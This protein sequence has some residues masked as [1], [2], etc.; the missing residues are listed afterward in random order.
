MKFNKIIRNIAW[1]AVAAFCVVPAN[2][3]TNLPEGAFPTLITPHQQTINYRERTLCLDITANVAY[4]F[5]SDAEWAT[6]RK[7]ADGSVYLHL[8][9]NYGGESRVANITFTCATNPELNQTLV[10]TQGRNEAVEDLP[11]DTQIKP[12]SATANNSQSGNGIEKTYDGDLDT[13]YHT[14][15]TGNRFTV[16]ESNPAI[17]TYNFTDVDRIDYVQYVPRRDNVTNGNFMNVEV[18]VKREGDADYTTYATYEWGGGSSP[19]TVNFEGG[20]LNPVSI[21]FVV[22]KGVGDHASC[23][24]MQFCLLNESKDDVFNLFKDDLCSELKDGVTLADIE[25]CTSTFAQSLAMQLYNGTYEKNY[26]IAEYPC[27]LDPQVLS[28]LWNVPGKLYDQFDGVTGINITK[29][30]SAVIVSGIPDTESLVLKIVAW[31]EGKDGDSFDGG[32]PNIFTYSLKNGINVIDYTFDYDGLAYVCYYTTSAP[33]TKPNV[34]VHFVNGQI[35]GYLSPDKTN[36]EMH[37]LCANAKSMFMDAVGEKVHSV[38][39]AEGFYK[40]CKASD[41]TSIGYRQFMNVLDSLI[42]WEHYLLG[43]DKYDLVPNN[44]TFAYTNYTYYMFQGGLGVSFHHNQESRVLNCRNLIYTD[45]DAI[46]GLSHEW[47]HQHQMHPYFCWAGMTE[48]TNN[49]N[50]YYNIM[51]MGYYTS[52]K[53]NQWA[54]ARRHFLNDETLSTNEDGGTTNTNGVVTSSKRQDA[55]TLANSYSYSPEMKALCEAMQSGVISKYADNPA[56]AVHISEVGVGETLCPFIMLYNYA[57]LTLGLKD[58]APDMYEALR[59]TDAVNGSVIEKH[60]GVD[61]YELIA[62]AQNGNKN[63]SL[64]LLKN[65]YPNS[66]WVTKNYITTAHCSQNNNHAP[67]VLNYI[68]KVSRLIGY[69]LFPYF[70]RWGF[71]RQIALNIGDYGNKP[72]IMTEAMYNEFK[73]DMDA[74]VASGE[75]KAMPEGMVEEISNTRDINK[76]ASDKLFPTPQI[77][78]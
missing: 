44:H 60:N 28:D 69:N 61:K 31:Y 51:R 29:G 18:Q 62:S 57:T 23:A 36:E 63:Q 54:P 67:Y 64:T 22:T 70:E 17:L 14:A 59:Q 38:W 6:L 35:N 43:F 10:V 78:N 4:E 42:A 40:Y 1:A 30:K 13:Y 46:W 3:Q 48:V 66:C 45:D 71:L 37:Q 21:R 19:Q 33:E 16:S 56:R 77:P 58:F 20:L 76:S 73:E 11:V 7:G 32:N 72:M 55:Y 5:G 75:L 39:T 24:E 8:L 74:L 12:S 50:S 9:A 65:Q 15:W 68:R 49:M 25:A 41:G 34:K 27:R 47:G 2:A 52:D 26:R 53:I